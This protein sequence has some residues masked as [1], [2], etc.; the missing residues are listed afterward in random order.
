MDEEFKE[1]QLPPRQ[2]ALTFA[3][4][5]TPLPKGLVVIRNWKE[6][7]IAQ[8]FEFMSNEGLK[9]LGVVVKDKEEGKKLR[10]RM[11]SYIHKLRKKYAH[12]LGRDMEYVK[13]ELDRFGIYLRVNSRGTWIVLVESNPQLVNK[14]GVEG[15]EVKG[16]LL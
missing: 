15:E 5:S 6:A 12:Q 7:G 13:Q 11:T 3:S 16:E 9:H 4:T 10:N 2:N 14:D 1:V 8:V